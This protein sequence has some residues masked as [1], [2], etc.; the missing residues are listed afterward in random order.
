M[1]KKTHQKILRIVEND[2]KYLEIFIKLNATL[3]DKGILCA[4]GKY[5]FRRQM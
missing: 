2:S 1:L 3:I 4:W 5:P